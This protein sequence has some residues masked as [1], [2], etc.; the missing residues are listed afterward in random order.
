MADITLNIGGRQFRVACEDGEQER[1]RDAAGLLDAEA[2]A[3][4]KAIG[5]VPE[6]RM[7]LMAGLM[8]ADR[9]IGQESR[10][11]GTEEALR[12]TR[13]RL[14]AAESAV[15]AHHAAPDP[16]AIEIENL[17]DQA[18]DL[19]DRTAARLEAIAES[20]EPAES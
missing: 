3:L 4:S 6:S 15:T 20:L 7:L 10:H 14:R 12:E 8:L 9:M 18:V 17:A 19:L 2:D 5:T 1:L 16:R 11:R 13:A